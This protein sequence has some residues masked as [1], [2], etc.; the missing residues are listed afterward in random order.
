M[1]LESLGRDPQQRLC[2]E[3]ARRG[4]HGLVAGKSRVATSGGQQQVAVPGTA[5]LTNYQQHVARVRAAESQ[6]QQH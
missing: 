3:L 2:K 1:H 5:A 6:N 4:Q